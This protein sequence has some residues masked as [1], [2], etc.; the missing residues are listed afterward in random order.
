MQ[1]V[2]Y[3]RYYR[4]LHDKLERP[5]LIIVDGGISQIHAAKEILDSL[6][7]DIPIVGLKKNDKHTTTSLISIEKEYDIDKASDLFHLLTRMQDEVHRFT[8]SYHKDIRSKGQLSSI[9]DNVPGIGD[10]RKKELLKKY[11][12]ITRLKELN[13]EELKEDLPDKVAEDLYDFLKEYK[14]D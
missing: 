11:K 5:D 12:T 14:K 10:K 9:L 2:I 4:V 13:K 1:E 7:L 3:R 6:Y 8:I